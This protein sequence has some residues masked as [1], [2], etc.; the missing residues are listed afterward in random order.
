MIDNTKMADEKK[1]EV[2]FDFCL[3]LL[4]K[5]QQ[6]SATDNDGSVTS[7]LFE[8]LVEEATHPDLQ[9]ILKQNRTNT[10]V[11]QQ[12]FKLKVMELKGEPL[13]PAAA[14]DDTDYVA[15]LEK[16]L[17]PNISDG[18]YK[19][20]MNKLLIEGTLTEDQKHQV[21]I[22]INCKDE[23]Q[24]SDMMDDFKLSFRKAKPKKKKE[25]KA[26]GEK[27]APQLEKED[28]LSGDLRTL[29]SRLMDPK[30]KT[31]ARDIY[32]RLM[33]PNVDIDYK[34]LAIKLVDPSNKG[35]KDQ[36]LSEFDRDMRIRKENEEKKKAREE[37]IRKMALEKKKIE[38]RKRQEKRDLF[39]KK[40]AE[41]R[42]NK[43]STSVGKFESS[44]TEEQ[45]RI[46]REKEREQVRLQLKKMREEK[47]DPVP[48]GGASRDL[49]DDR[50]SYILLPWKI[51]NKLGEVSLE[52][53]EVSKLQ[54][55]S[56]SEHKQLLL[57]SPFRTKEA[58]QDKSG[59]SK[60]PDN[61]DAKSANSTNIIVTNKDSPGDTNT[62][63]PPDTNQDKDTNK[64][65]ETAKPP[66][67][68]ENEAT[69]SPEFLEYF[70][71]FSNPDL[72]EADEVALLKTLIF[73]KKFDLVKDLVIEISSIE[74]RG[75]SKMFSKLCDRYVGERVFKQSE[76][77][78]QVPDDA[79][80]SEQKDQNSKTGSLDIDQEKTKA[81]PTNESSSTNDT[82]KDLDKNKDEITSKNKTEDVIKDQDN[83]NDDKETSKESIKKQENIT[84]NI[85]DIAEPIDRKVKEDEYDDQTESTIEDN[86]NK[87]K[88]S[89][90]KSVAKESNEKVSD[91]TKKSE[92]EDTS[93]DKTKGKDRDANKDKDANEDKNAKK[94]K[95]AKK[96]KE[97]QNETKEI[98]SNK[99]NK[100]KDKKTSKESNKSKGISEMKK[101]KDVDVNGTT[102]NIEEKDGDE[103]KKANK[104]SVRFRSVSSDVKSES[105]LSLSM[106]DIRNKFK[107]KRIDVYVKIKKDKRLYK[108][109]L[110]QHK[111][112]V[113]ISKTLKRKLSTNDNNEEGKRRKIN[114]LFS[115]DSSGSISSEEAKVAN[116]SNDAKAPIN[117]KITSSIDVSSDSQVAVNGIGDS[118]QVKVQTE[119]LST[120]KS[121]SLSRSK[122]R[123]LS[124][125][126]SRSLSRSR[127]R[128]RSL[129][130]SKSRSKS[131]SRSLSRTSSRSRSLSRSTSRSKSR[132]RSLSRSSRSMS[133]SRSKSKSR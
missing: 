41:E 94:D 107:L 49:K 124:R 34:N 10:D 45:R 68:N 74:G 6:A 110:G 96:D 103:C 128:S 23:K 24:R 12:Q 118:S 129:S 102:S 70:D 108:A 18:E 97:S 71:K 35:M 39:L 78:K 1:I 84:A 37:E 28:Y 111:N 83:K 93:K 31:V 79:T 76:A 63:S 13:P 126:K 40:R 58:N 16:L 60:V 73:E 95:D 80:N 87:D 21:S 42:R 122:S 125:S 67:A 121:E 81:A 30:Y 59:T 47:R 75:K 109:F 65:L 26:E 117:G 5:L 29:V 25:K 130:R 50:P 106:Q 114:P 105:I 33:E 90:E 54:T 86:V 48:G 61:I 27:T 85:K 51:D 113:E 91:E 89:T 92:D 88:D 119:S 99:D 115:D 57:L 100:N 55:L 22:I 56:E 131:R 20:T 127:S 77:N 132:S 2:D 32:D 7:N 8:E 62:T 112:D 14:P 43:H 66:K 36:L 46:E 82:T 98:S 52:V 72:A 4:D 9:E 44:K 69:K 101:E 38:D 15:L 133:R 17:D 64:E 123:S 19:P 104:K 3:S 120:N 116:K 53:C 11:L